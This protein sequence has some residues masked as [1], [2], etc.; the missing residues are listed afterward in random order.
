MLKLGGLASVCLI[1]LLISEKG[2]CPGRFSRGFVQVAAQLARR[3]DSAVCCA[4]R[5]RVSTTFWGASRGFKGDKEMVDR[6]AAPRGIQ[7]LFS[8]F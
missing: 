6:R 3:A 5:E 2:D 7:Y 8:F 4:T 1:H